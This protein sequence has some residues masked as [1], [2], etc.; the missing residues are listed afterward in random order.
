MPGNCVQ[1]IF[2]GVDL[3]FC[4]LV[5]LQLFYDIDRLSELEHESCKVICE[6]AWNGA[7]VSGAFAVTL[8]DCVDERPSR[9]SGSME[10]PLRDELVFA[11]SE[12]LYIHVQLLAQDCD[13]G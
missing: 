7:Q 4:V 6:F 13:V 3:T 1:E 8:K 5:F 12:L 11:V 2:L 9:C 10:D